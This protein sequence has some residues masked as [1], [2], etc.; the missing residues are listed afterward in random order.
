MANEI[1]EN[2]I[3]SEVVE[4]SVEETKVE[5]VNCESEEMQDKVAVEETSTPKEKTITRRC[6]ECGKDFTYSVTEAEWLK[7]NG[8]EPYKRCPACRKKR[9][10]EREK[11]NAETKE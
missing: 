5:E 4:N 1:I 7:A 3:Q 11:Q 9:K 10:E 6:K 8:L 2:S